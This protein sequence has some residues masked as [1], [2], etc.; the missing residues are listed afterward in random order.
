[1]NS[2]SDLKQFLGNMS[3]EEFLANYWEKKPLLVRGAVKNSEE[4]ISPETMIEMAQDPEIESRLVLEEDGDFPWE[5]I[6][7]EIKEELFEKHKDH[8]WTLINHGVNN[9]IKDFHNLELMASFIPSWNF[10]DVMIT[11]SKKGGNVAPHID[12]Y[13]VFIIQGHGVKKWQINENSDTEIYPD[14]E[15]KVLKNFKSE[16]EWDLNPGDM[17]YL[18]PHVAHYGVAQ[19][20]GMSYSIG[21][22]SINHQELLSNYLYNIIDEHNEDKIH[23]YYRSEKSKTPL[24]LDQDTLKELHQIVKESVD[25]SDHFQKWF[26]RYITRPRY[27]PE[28]NDPI[29]FE[30]FLEEIKEGR[31][32][33]KETYLKSFYSQ[34][35]GN[36][37]L[38][39]NQKDYKISSEALTLEAVEILNKFPMEP[40]NIEREMSDEILEIF[41]ELYQQGD[42]FFTE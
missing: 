24:M 4:M 10:D 21:F 6:H 28:A 27:F 35:D 37:H 41:F 7:G 26:G 13:N 2:L 8:C 25:N 15:V 34:I 29:N 39:I 11:Y 9:Y 36:H 18:P 31:S 17:L 42:V 3:V 5:I 38:F 14:M 19:T 40:L 30:E 22:N 32:L 1:M 16:Q 12:S 20:D 33:F 23:R